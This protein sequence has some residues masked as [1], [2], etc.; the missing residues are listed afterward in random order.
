MRGASLLLILFLLTPAPARADSDGY[1]CTGRGYIAW[2]TRLETAEHQLHIVRFSR[3]GGL[4]RQA[5]IRLEEFQVH[6]MTCAEQSVELVGGGKHHTVDLSNVARPAVTTR[7][8]SGNSAGVEQMNLGHW[9]REG[10]IDLESDAAPGEFQLVISKVSRR[11]TGGV[12]HYTVTQIIRR[13]PAA[14]LER[15]L[16]SIRLFEGIFR[17]T[18]D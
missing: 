7:A 5:S 10:V 9:S 13:N 17:E 16:Q 1:Y 15:I 4:V 3:D 6:A 14:G 18:V 2:E 8:A 12:D 11:V